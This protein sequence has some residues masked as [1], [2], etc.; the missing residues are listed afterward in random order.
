[1]QTSLKTDLTPLKC[2]KNDLPA[3]QVFAKSWMREESHV[4]PSSVKTR[5]E[6]QTEERVQGRLLD[7]RALFGSDDGTASGAAIRRAHFGS[8]T[9]E[10]KPTERREM[11]TARCGGTTRR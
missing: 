7:R 9:G 2:G 8:G 10:A 6:G 4:V 11:P 5:M 3:G 1:M